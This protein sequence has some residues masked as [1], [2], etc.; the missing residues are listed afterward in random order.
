MATATGPHLKL[1]LKL[2]WAALLVCS[3]AVYGHQG[4][5]PLLSNGALFRRTCSYWSLCSN[6]GTI[7]TDR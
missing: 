6:F 3:A 2:S 7:C 1:G 4:L 5:S